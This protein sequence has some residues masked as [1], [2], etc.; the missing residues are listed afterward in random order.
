MGHIKLINVI[1]FDRN[2]GVN[3]LN[4]V[5]LAMNGTNM[6]PKFKTYKKQLAPSD[7]FLSLPQIDSRNNGLT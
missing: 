4:L 3:H 5:I 2:L 1:F 7:C 6:Q